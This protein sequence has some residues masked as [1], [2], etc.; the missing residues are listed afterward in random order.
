MRL[1]QLDTGGQAMTWQWRR[2]PRC[3]ALARS[4]MRKALAGWGL[5]RIEG[6]A[7]LVVSELVTNAVVHAGVQGREV[8]TRFVRL[9]GGVRIEVHDASDDRP[10]RRVPDGKGGFGLHLVEQF[11]ARWG[12]AERAIGKTVWAVV[13]DPEWVRGDLGEGKGEVSCGRG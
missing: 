11:A 3:V 13:V 7:V 4:Q 5:V 12:V 2:H 8:S 9:D 6:P 1:Q 10:V